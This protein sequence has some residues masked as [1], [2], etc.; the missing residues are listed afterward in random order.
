[1][2]QKVR[3][4]KYYWELKKF[5][6]FILSERKDNARQLGK[7]VTGRMFF[8]LSY[9]NLSFLRLPVFSQYILE[10]SFV[11]RLKKKRKGVSKQQVKR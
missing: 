3:E 4:N 7:T 8:F 9:Y 5:L 10:Q 1:M 6:L 11:K 2:Y